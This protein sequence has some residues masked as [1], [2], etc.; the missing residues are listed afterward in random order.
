[1]TTAYGCVV[2]PARRRTDAAESAP[3]P[4]TVTVVS[5]RLT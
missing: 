4:A 2:R 3:L 1:M 5:G